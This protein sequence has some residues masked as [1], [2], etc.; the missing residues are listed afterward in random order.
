[1]RKIGGI[2][3]W[4]WADDSGPATLLAFMGYRCIAAPDVVA[5]EDVPRRFRNNLGR[6]ARRAIHLIHLFLRMEKEVNNKDLN[7]SKAFKH[8]YLLEK[9]L[10]LVNPWILAFATI[11]LL[12][13]FII[14]PF[15]SIYTALTLAVAV[16]CMIASKAYRTWLLT[17]VI[18]TYAFIKNIFGKD[19]LMWEPVKEIRI[20]RHQA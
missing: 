13:D 6:R 4:V 8:I 10:H 9:T 14:N 11:L 17:Q 7:P 1:L 3:T 16:G 20:G 5:Y 18:L 2:P 12:T 15:N 19:L